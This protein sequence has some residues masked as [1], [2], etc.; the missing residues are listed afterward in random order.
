MENQNNKPAQ[1]NNDQTAKEVMVLLQGIIAIVTIC[2]SLYVLITVQKIK[3]PPIS[4]WGAS[5]KKVKRPEVDY[6]TVIVVPTKAPLIKKA[7]LADFQ[8]ID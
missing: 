2:F 6:A 3:K 5:I 8:E 4:L 7:P 1:Q